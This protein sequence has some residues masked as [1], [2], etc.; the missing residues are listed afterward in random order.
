MVFIV[1]L[2]MED[3]RAYEGQRPVHQPQA[4]GTDLETSRS[5]GP[6]KTAQEEKI[7]AQ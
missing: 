5:Q 3:H 6:V 7:A 2:L 1:H 4:S